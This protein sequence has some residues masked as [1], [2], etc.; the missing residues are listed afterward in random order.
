MSKSRQSWLKS[1]NQL[2]FPL[3][4][5]ASLVA[6][7]LDELT[8]NTLFQNRTLVRQTCGY[9]CY[10]APQSSQSPRR[11][12][13]LHQRIEALEHLAWRAMPKVSTI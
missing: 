3:Q 4:A 8:V 7:D 12:R 10:R 1:P 9:F 11:H 6:M 5:L 2:G 13:T